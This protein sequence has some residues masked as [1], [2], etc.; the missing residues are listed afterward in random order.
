[1]KFLIIFLF[2]IL[3]F[4]Y[5]LSLLFKKLN[6]KTQRRDNLIGTAF[7]I[8]PLLNIHNIDY[9][10]DFDT[11]SNWRKYN[12]I[13]NSM[14]ELNISIIENHKKKFKSHVL[15]GLKYKYDLEIIRL[16]SKDEAMFKLKNKLTNVLFN[17]HLVKK[18]NSDGWLHYYNPF[19]K[20]IHYRNAVPPKLEN[21]NFN[22][23]G[24]L[25]IKVPQNCDSI[26]NLKKLINKN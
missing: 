25:K 17:I 16:A 4:I 15:P 1:M 26:I 2:I 11:L 21:A 10:I 19:I 5:L 8:F 3:P 24:V 20:P 6:N 14:N 13:T 22:N 23:Y 9:W 12:E 7:D 18:E